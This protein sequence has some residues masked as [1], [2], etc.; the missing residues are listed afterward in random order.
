MPAHFFLDASALT[1]RYLLE[2]G[3][4]QIN[5][6]M[7][8]AS[9]TRLALLK[10]TRLEII[11]VL[12]RARNRATI[13]VPEFQQALVNL[14]SDIGNKVPLIRIS[15]TDKRIAAAAKLIPTHSINATDALVLASSIELS[16]RL[17]AAGDSLVLV[18]ADQRLHK[19]ARA[20]GLVSFDPETQSQA[21]LDVL[22]KS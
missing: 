20:E 15:A 5:H 7:Q 2:K 8:Q 10:L 6:L 22:L 4:A 16:R 9:S 11:S 18:A 3:S 14:R 21:E 19:A 12:V 1:K 17:L 13:T